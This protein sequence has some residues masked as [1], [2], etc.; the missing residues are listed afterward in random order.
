MSPSNRLEKL[1][2]NFNE[3]YCIRINQQWGIIFIWNLGNANE[4]K[5][6]DYY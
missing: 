6:I 5:I 4:V 3:F 1:S 2:G